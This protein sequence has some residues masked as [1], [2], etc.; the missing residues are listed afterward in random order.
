MAHDKALSA[1]HHVVL[2]DQQP[3]DYSGFILNWN[4]TEEQGQ[5]YLRD[6]K[7]Q[8]GAELV[9]LEEGRERRKYLV[10]TQPLE[11]AKGQLVQHLEALHR[12]RPM[13][14]GIAVDDLAN[15]LKVGADALFKAALA[16]LL[17][18]QD[19]C[20]SNG[21]LSMTGHRPTVSSQVQQR[22]LLFSTL[23]RKGGYQVPLLSEIEKDTGLN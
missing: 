9:V 20:I 13:E 17:K 8:Q 2:D 10:P 23:L 11:Q 1:L 14:T 7:L 19:V 21:F 15:Q 18:E 12:E 16:V 4:S 3:L 6:Q 5:A 22:W